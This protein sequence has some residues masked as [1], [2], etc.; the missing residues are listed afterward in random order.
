M[1]AGGW[2]IFRHG[3][4][5]GRTKAERL[6]FLPEAV[7]RWRERNPDVTIDEVLRKSYARGHACTP[8]VSGEDVYERVLDSMD[9]TI[10]AW[11]EANRDKVFDL[12]AKEE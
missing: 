7:Q 1:R 12:I 9:P 6:M 10:A 4:A 5:K 8:C 2:T 3:K 11:M